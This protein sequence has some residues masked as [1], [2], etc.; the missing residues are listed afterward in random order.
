MRIARFVL[1]LALL[2]ACSS[3]SSD[4]SSAAQESA[5]IDQNVHKVIPLQFA[6]ARDL[7]STLRSVLAAPAGQ[8]SPL[9][10][11][12]ERTNSLVVSCAPEQL[13]TIEKL[14][15]ELDVQT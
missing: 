3:T 7:A 10:V 2:A 12:D 13:A 9:I 15:A 11:P 8:P 4:H 6:P 14:V 1:L 5:R